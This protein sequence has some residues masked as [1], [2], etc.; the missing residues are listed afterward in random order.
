MEQTQ[1]VDSASHDYTGII[2]IRAPP[3]DVDDRCGSYIEVISEREFAD[4]TQVQV[5]TIVC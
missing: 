3:V 2:D 1:Q 4:Q 5:C